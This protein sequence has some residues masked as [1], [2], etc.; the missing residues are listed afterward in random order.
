MAKV[1][2]NRKNKVGKSLQEVLKINKPYSNRTLIRSDD[3]RMD[4]I[5]SQESKVSM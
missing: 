2:P 3:L 1:E 5:L 4:F